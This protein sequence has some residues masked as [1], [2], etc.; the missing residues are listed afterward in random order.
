[1]AKLSILFVVLLTFTGITFAQ[2]ATTTGRVD[3]I[4]SSNS[5]NRS[6]E[7]AMRIED[8]PT[9]YCTHVIYDNIELEAFTLT[10][11]PSNP[12]YDILENGWEKFIDLKKNNPTLK[13]LMSVKSVLT[14]T[15]IET[16]A[17]RA[18]FIDVIVSI[19]KEYKF[20]GVSILW[21]G[22]WNKAG[23]EEGSLYKLFE[24]M[25]RSF[26]ASG[27]PD[28]EA[29]IIIIIDQKDIDHS[30]ICRVADSVSLLSM[31]DHV[32]QPSAANVAAPLNNLLFETGELQNVSIKH[33][34]QKWLNNGCP[35]NKIIL[36][37]AFVGPTYILAD[38]K[39]NGLGSP[40]IGPGKAC[41]ITDNEGSCA[42]F[43]V[44]QKYNET[45]WTFKWDEENASPYAFQDD[46]WI[47]YENVASI[48]RKASFAKSKGLAGVLGMNLS[49]DDYRGKCGE[50]YPLTKALWKGFRT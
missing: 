1:M 2:E 24:E 34:L 50:K 20:D 38:T 17:Q 22:Y 37:L 33:S 3:C 41:S 49:N 29:N 19:L 30:R 40:I 4:F 9:D 27:H 48:E 35:A 26:D 15:F 23:F 36:G 39:K 45:E 7:Y 43:E 44:C 31:L 13:F 14:S 11:M 32:N 21:F 28:W 42:Y 8:I 47:G 46:Q 16:A 12:Q 25:R 10:I 5:V 18:E 6:G